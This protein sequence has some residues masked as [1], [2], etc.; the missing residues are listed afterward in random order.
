MILTP[1]GVGKVGYASI[2]GKAKRSEAP[3][4]SL[5]WCVG[6][7]RPAFGEARPLWAA[8]YQCGFLFSEFES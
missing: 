2:F 4:H 5:E 3:Y 1:L 8:G 6:R 7:I